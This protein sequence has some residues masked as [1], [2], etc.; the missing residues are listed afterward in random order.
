MCSCEKTL[1]G[2]STEPK[3]AA[4]SCGF[5]AQVQFFDAVPESIRQ[6]KIH[7]SNVGHSFN[8]DTEIF[9]APVDGL[10]V[11]SISLC[12]S[13]NKNISVGVRYQ[14]RLSQK[15]ASVCDS[16]ASVKGTTTC[17][18]GVVGMKAG[19]IL[20]SRVYVADCL[21]YR[22]TSALFSFAKSYMPCLSII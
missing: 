11:A 16:S 21:T 3:P 7:Y 8:A 15:S 10:Y 22:C 18:V 13:D 1:I 4:T 12:L 2:S 14:Q 19:D 6:Y 9:T 17:C 20:F 5:S